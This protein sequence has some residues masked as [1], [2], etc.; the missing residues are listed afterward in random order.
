MDSSGN[1]YGTASVG[2]AQA[3][4]TVFEL[5]KGSGTITTLASFNG[6]NGA[7]PRASL[8][9]DSSGN[10][11]GAASAGGAHGDGTV[12][13][14][15]KGSSTITVLASFNGTN[16][17]KPLATL[18]MDGSGNLYGTTASGGAGAVG[19]V[20]E[21]ANGSGTITT[22]A[23]FNGT[24]GAN[25][26]AGLVVDSSG[27]LYGTTTSGTSSGGGTVFELAKGSGTITKLAA[28]NGYPG[29]DPLGALI[30]DS[31][32]NLYGTTASGV[33]GGGGSVFELAQGTGTITTLALFNETEGAKLE[34]GLV[35]DSSGNL[36]GTASAG[37]ALQDGDVFE[38]AKGSGT[39]TTLASFNGTNGLEPA[40]G[41][42]MDSSGN[43]YGTTI[44]GGT[45]SDGTVFELAHGSGN[46]IALASFNGTNGAAP[47]AALILDSSGN[48]YGTTDEGGPA[49]DGTVFELAHGTG[50]ITTLASFNGTNGAQPAAGLI[51]DGS[52]NLYGTTMYGTVFE[53][54]KGSGTIT[55]LATC[56]IPYGTLIMDSSGNLYGTTSEGGAGDVG[57]VFE[58][59]K[60]SGTTTTLASFN[61]TNGA[62]P[63]AGLVMDGSGNLYGT[64]FRGGAS[65]EGAVFELARG[66][67]TLAALASFNT[68][69]GG[70]DAGLIIDSSGN[71][72]GTTY[73]GGAGNLGTVF[74]VINPGTTIAIGGFPSRDT[75]GVA[76]TFSVTAR[77]ADGTTDSAY[78][79]TVHFTSSDGQAGLP[80]DYTF[81]AADAGVHR[82]TAALK[83][84]GTQSLAA[85]DTVTGGIFGSQAGIVVT[86]AAASQLIIGG[87]PGVKHGVAFTFTVSMVDVYGNIATGYVGTVHFRSS[88]STATLPA[89][90]TFTAADAGQH[91][92]IKQTI[93]RKKGKQTLTLIDT[94]NSALTDTE[95]VSVA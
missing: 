79:G 31:T 63:Y 10:L 51:M 70:S 84:A 39:I 77:N 47:E 29:F 5:A 21:L 11:Y 40:A 1:L 48:L 30:I 73:E 3:D 32:G 85:A 23:S 89:N 56:S 25:P 20:F 8:I 82:F 94:L 67:G 22:L 93:L 28:F 36:Y 45:S 87:L 19:T 74:E 2:G 68:L 43:L 83:T 12:F 42:V 60:G 38:L 9:M 91:T 62:N 17:V 57:T 41:L 52:G 37:G 54:A 44:F 26:D 88:D 95:S 59:A 72:Y 53:L 18:I 13:E 69:Y 78:T 49:N 7:T 65:G 76:A 6:T 75:A 27:N 14:L 81:T 24:N 35:M 86:P 55:T 71:L 92:F 15:A 66:S 64:T 80:A 34:A 33:L 61:G 46:I 90:Y 4:G 58:L 50:T 16:G